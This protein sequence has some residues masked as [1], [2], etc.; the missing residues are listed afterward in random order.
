MN[1]PIHFLKDK[2]PNLQ[3]LLRSLSRFRFEAISGQSVIDT[4]DHPNPDD[5]VYGSHQAMIQIASKDLRVTFK[6][7]F[8]LSQTKSLSKK[9]GLKPIYDLFM[10]YSNLVAGGLSQD[11]HKNHIVSGISL[12]MATSGFDE[13]I[14]SD[15]L[16]SSSYMDYWLVK[17]LDFQFTCT[18]QVDFLAEAWLDSFSF[19][20]D[21]GETSSELEFL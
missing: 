17:G 5:F 14:A 12:P 2:S 15:P 18:T 10:E 9:P 13:L 3:T 4:K 6:S 20:E 21:K 1:K 8:T 16:R 19:T 11:L 7:H